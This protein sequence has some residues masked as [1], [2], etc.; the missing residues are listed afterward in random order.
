M[1]H[2]GEPR[3]EHRAAQVEV[4]CLEANGKQLALPHTAEDRQPGPAIRVEDPCGSQVG[5]SSWLGGSSGA[6]KAFVG[7]GVQREM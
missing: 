2:R 3:V 5:D 6:S 4:T 7:S 1:E